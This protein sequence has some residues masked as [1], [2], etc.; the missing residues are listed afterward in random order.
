MSYVVE[1]VLDAQ[2]RIGEN[3][4]WSVREQALYFIDVFGQA[5]HRFEPNSGKHRVLPV[6][7]RIGCIGLRAN[8]GFVAAMRSGV[9]FLDANGSVERMVAENPLGADKSRFNDGRVDPFG[10]FW[11]GTLWEPRDRNG[12]KLF[13]LDG[14][15]NFT[16]QADDVLVSNGLAFSPNRDWVFHADTAHNVLYRYPMDPDSGEIGARETLRQFD[17]E[18][19][20][21]DGAAFDCEGYYW[22]AMVGGGRVLRLHPTTGEIEDEIKVPVPWP[23]MI[24]FGGADMKTLYITTLREFRTAGELAMYP[25][26]GNVFATR[27]DVAGVRDPYF[28]ESCTNGD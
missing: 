8:G 11:C 19:G 15:L 20:K 7:E 22:C 2:T 10:R 4:V 6:A 21:I 14:Q 5:I 24:G 1:S 9:F 12:G 18:L 26:T 17:N 27:V 16:A 23:T 28:D 3:P 13:R 25:H